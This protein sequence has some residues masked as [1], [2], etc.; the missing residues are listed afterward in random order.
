MIDLGSGDGV[1]VL[2]AARQYKA[3]GMGVD[4]DPE[5]VKLSNEKAIRS[6]A[7]PTACASCS[8]T[9]SRPT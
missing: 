8:R 7:S 3:S 4:I 5:L 9:C 1:I 2:T 6:W